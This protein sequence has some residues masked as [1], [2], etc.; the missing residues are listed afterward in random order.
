MLLRL[1]RR[2]HPAFDDRGFGN[3]AIAASSL[4]YTVRTVSSLVRR[5]NSI[6]YILEDTSLV[7]LFGSLFCLFR[8]E[9]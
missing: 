4:A 8:F 9:K 3:D 5:S 1:T 2:Y 7:P 6:K